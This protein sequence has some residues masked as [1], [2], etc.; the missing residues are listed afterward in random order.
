MGYNARNSLKIVM[1]HSAES[2]NK[3]LTLYWFSGSGNT[4][5]LAETF[6]AKLSELGWEVVLEPLERADPARF[7]PETVLGLAFSTHC[8]SIPEMIRRF[9]HAL[10]VANGTPAMMLGS[11]GAFSGGVCG[12]MKRL[13]STKGYHCVAGRIFVMPDSFFPY[14]G[15][16]FN[17][18]LRDRAQK[19]VESFA[20]RFH[21]GQTHWRYWPVLSDLFGYL[22]GA[23]FASRKLFP[24]IHTTVGIRQ[25]RCTQ[26]GVCVSLCPVHA[27]K[28]KSTGDV[29]KPDRTC[30]NCLRCVAVC[31]TDAVKHC[32]GFHPY[33]NE[34]AAE[35]RRHFEKELKD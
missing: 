26:C 34:N 23:F 8:F 12:P 33:R 14:T 9:V 11:H 21:R 18:F 10:P 6:A 15:E 5:R 3:K 30:V 32:F 29:P 28:Q 25:D 35:L 1:S 2:Q 13:L 20:E 4:L 7:D 27:L 31:P 17:R 22:F 24:R 16:R 19:Q